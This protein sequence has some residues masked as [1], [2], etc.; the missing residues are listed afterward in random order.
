MIPCNTPTYTAQ[1]FSNPSTIKLEQK[2]MHIL[3][4]YMY[5]MKNFT[6]EEYTRMYE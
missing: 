4:V 5:R 3:V 6:E 1:A 2:Y